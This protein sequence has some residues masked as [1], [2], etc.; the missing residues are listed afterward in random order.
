M[1]EIIVKLGDNVVQKYF[2]HRESMTIG[3]AQDN[4][5]VIE[6][7]AI[8]RNH[9]VVKFG[10]EDH[11]FIEDLGSSNGTLINGNKVKRQEIQDKDVITVGKHELFFYNH[12]A[13][14]S[15]LQKPELSIDKTVLVQPAA[16]KATLQVNKGRQKDLEFTIDSPLT[17]IGR[18][19]DND[20]RLTDWFVS[21]NHAQIERREGRFVL[22]DLDS[23]RHTTVNGE[24]I[25]QTILHDGDEIQFG[26]TVKL[27][28]SNPAEADGRP[29]APLGKDV[30]AASDAEMKTQKVPMDAIEEDVDP[31]LGCDMEGVLTN[32]PSAEDPWQLIE[33]EHS[34]DEPLREAGL[35]GKTP[36]LHDSDDP[37][38]VESA[39]ASAEIGDQADWD[40]DAASASEVEEESEIEPDA[41][42]IDLEGDF[43]NESQG[44]IDDRPKEESLL[45]EVAEMS[46]KVAAETL[47][48]EEK[49]GKLTQKSAENQESIDNPPDNRNHPGE[50]SNPDFE[51]ELQIWKRALQNKSQ[52][53]RKQAAR[54]LK[55]L[56]GKDYDY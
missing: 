15:E 24:I 48:E 23:W 17:T 29:L 45:E 46:L 47:E 14:E 10:E 4:D 44:K 49:K 22:R 42:P 56:T 16:P 32:P 40:F 35:F 20:I 39:S 41:E 1:P 53:I 55:K 54:Q 26:P 8:S 30:F 34:S 7:L 21:K 33:A 31:L 36:D 12:R 13:N 38:S 50:Q 43:F 2:F 9:A 27:A 3:R 18:G 19:T 37:E 6:N 52:V 5:I 51:A 11:Y 25:E 28:F